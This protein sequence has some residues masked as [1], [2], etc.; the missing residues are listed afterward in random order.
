LLKKS[1]KNNKTLVT[2]NAGFIAL[3]EL[4]VLDIDNEMDWKM[5]EL[6]YKLI[7]GK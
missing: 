7:Y 4:H 2:K 5:A 1:L 3:D 6:K